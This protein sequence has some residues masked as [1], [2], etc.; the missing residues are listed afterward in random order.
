MTAQII[1]DRQSALDNDAVRP[2]AFVHAVF[3]TARYRQL[4]D[5]YLAFLNA[6][7]VMAAPTVS[8]LTYDD[9]HHRIAIAHVP[10]LRDLD[11]GSSGLEHISYAY[12]TL[13]DLLAN[14]VRLKKLGITPFWS[15]N[16]GP[17]TSLYYR[18]PDGNQIETQVDNF[19]TSEEL[20]AFFSTDQFRKNPMGVQFDPDRL[21]ERYRAGDPEGE[22][23]SQGAAPIPPG[24]GYT[25]P[26]DGFKEDRQAMSIETEIEALEA[27]RCAALIARDLAT[28]DALLADDLVHIHG[29]GGTDGK[30]GYLDGIARKYDFHA[31]SRGDLTIRSYGDVVVVTGPLSQTLSMKDAEERH[32]IEAMTTQVWV[33]AEGGW[34]Q[35]TC[36]N[37]FLP[38]G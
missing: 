11:P 1:A 19:A 31:V 17:T 37:Q 5:F 38:R 36:H 33:R 12:A 4:V 20:I 9:E 27:R 6:E 2:A 18:D 3:K 26:T 28:L 16:H 34:R 7:V 8:F 22:L 25:P 32:Q 30:A 29:N 23:K 24:T 35:T 10:S 13:G 15:I 21:V 14:Y